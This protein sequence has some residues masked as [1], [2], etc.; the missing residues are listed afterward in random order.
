MI[1]AKI[2]TAVDYGSLKNGDQ[3][4]AYAEVNGM[5]GV[6]RSHASICQQSFLGGL[7]LLPLYVGINNEEKKV[8]MCAIYRTNTSVSLNRAMFFM[9]VLFPMACLK[10]RNVRKSISRLAPIALSVF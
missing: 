5:F 8:S 1:L 2:I 7:Q 9:P 6:A 3:E 10:N 4:N